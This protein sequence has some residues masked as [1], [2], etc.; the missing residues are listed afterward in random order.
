MYLP[1]FCFYVDSFL[2]LWCHHYENTEWLK[3]ENYDRV[4]HFFTDRYNIIVSVP[5]CFL[6]EK[7]NSNHFV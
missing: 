3:S 2:T 5:M 6:K 1:L 7:H 4:C